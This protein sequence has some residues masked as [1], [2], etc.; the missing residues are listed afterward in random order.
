MS[1]IVHEHR[2]LRAHHVAKGTKH[3]WEKSHMIKV[4]FYKKTNFIFV[5][6]ANKKCANKWY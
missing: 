5:K 6:S 1:N 4:N 2:D 3:K